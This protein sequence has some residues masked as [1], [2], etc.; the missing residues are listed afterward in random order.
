MQAKLELADKPGRMKTLDVD[1]ADMQQKLAALEK[2][3]FS[4][5]AQRGSTQQVTNRNFNFEE[6]LKTLSENMLE[7]F[8]DRPLAEQ[9]FAGLRR[10][11]GLKVDL[12]PHQKYSMLWLKWREESYPHGSILADDM[13]LGKTLTILAYLKMVKD[14][15]EEALARKITKRV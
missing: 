5:A 2:P 7:V 14:E 8:E 13:G 15:R 1:S 3:K 12:L 4:V 6:M 10:P 9:D 11:E